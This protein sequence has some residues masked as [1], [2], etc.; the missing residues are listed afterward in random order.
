MIKC[1]VKGCK[2]ELACSGC[3]KCQ[4]HHDQE[5]YPVREQKKDNG[6]KALVK[7]FDTHNKKLDK[8]IKLLEELVELAHWK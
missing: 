7:I 1:K 6:K 8:V 4:K 3:G 2:D 5:I